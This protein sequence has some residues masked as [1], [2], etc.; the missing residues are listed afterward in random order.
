MTSVVSQQ[1]HLW[2]SCAYVACLWRNVM[3]NGLL[4]IVNH[5]NID[6]IDIIIIQTSSNS[7]I[8]DVV[9][10]YYYYTIHNLWTRVAFSSHSAYLHETFLKLNTHRRCRD[11]G[12]LWY[13]LWVA[14]STLHFSTAP[15]CHQFVYANWL[16][17]LVI[18]CLNF[19]QWILSLFSVFYSSQIEIVSLSSLFST[20]LGI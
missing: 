18:I 9:D 15:A 12:G 16:I 6:V 14:V 4:S 11:V 13:I 20:L 2:H 7:N 17:L 3:F 10:V 8:N 5:D 1:L 19:F